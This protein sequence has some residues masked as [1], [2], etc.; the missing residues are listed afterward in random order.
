M[1][2]LLFAFISLGVAASAM[3]LNSPHNKKPLEEPS[4]KVDENGNPYIHVPIEKRS[5]GADHKR[6]LV[7]KTSELG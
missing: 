7:R 2:K 1:G 5:V 6:H 3:E 4:M